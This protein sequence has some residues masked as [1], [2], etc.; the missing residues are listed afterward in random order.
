MNKQFYNLGSI[1]YAKNVPYKTSLAKDFLRHEKVKKALGLNGS[2]VFDKCNDLVGDILHEDVMKS[3][4]YMVEYLMKKNKILLYQGK[5]DL[6]DG[7]V[8]IEG[9]RDV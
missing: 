3:V 2:L 5:F 7:V 9:E 8:S 1:D 4:K 6:R